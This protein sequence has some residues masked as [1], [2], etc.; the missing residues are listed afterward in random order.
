MQSRML[1]HGLPSDDSESAQQTFH[2][3][4]IDILPTAKAGGLRSAMGQ[5]SY[6]SL[7]Q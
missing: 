2:T 1:H 4:P 6:V 7:L 3:Y 5:K